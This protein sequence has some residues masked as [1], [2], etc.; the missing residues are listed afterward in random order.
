MKLDFKFGLIEKQPAETFIN[1]IH[2][3]DTLRP[4]VVSVLGW[5]RS[6]SC[7]V[8]DS[9]SS[10][11]PVSGVYSAPLSAQPRAPLTQLWRILGF[12]Q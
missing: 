1:M 8:P 12:K 10:A 9:I 6:P 4:C 7:G 5:I 3:I 2:L 11:I